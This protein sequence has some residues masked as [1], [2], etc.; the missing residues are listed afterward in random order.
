MDIVKATVEDAS[1]ISRL[2]RSVAP[3]FTLQ[4]DGAG[5]EDFLK[6]IAPDA[7]AG[8]LV[9]PH[10][11]Y[12]KAVENGTLAGVVAVRDSTHLYHLFVDES[13]QRRGLSR[14]LWDHARAAVGEA[15]PGYF[16]V[17]STPYAQPVYARFGFVATGPR[18]ETKGIAFV[19]MRWLAA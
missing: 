1:A 9:D 14:Q 18:V 19:P 6:T 7:V 3:F 4:P 11:V 12:L 2:I 13:F 10:F 15:N 17:N 5:A 16:T 8:Y